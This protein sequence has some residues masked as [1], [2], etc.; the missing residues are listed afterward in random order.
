MTPVQSQS[1]DLVYSG[2]DVVARSKTGTG[3]TFAFGLPLIEK[4]VAN[5]ENEIRGGRELPLVLILEPTR[6]LALQVAQELGSV[7]GIH[8]MRVQ[9]MYGGSSFV[10]Q[11]RALRDG[12]HILVATPGRVLDHISRGTVDLSNVKHVV[13]DEGDT[14]LEMGFQKA[15]ES[16]IANVKEPGEKSRQAAAQSLQDDYD[17]FDDE[18]DTYDDDDEEEDEE[19]FPDVELGV[20]LPNGKR[21]VQM[22]L[23]SATMPGW[24]CGITDKHMKN[25]VFVDA[26]K[27]GENRLASTIKHLAMRM[28]SL[29]EPPRYG[30]RGGR[31]NSRMGSAKME[32]MKSY[33][34]DLILTKGK[35]GQTIV[36]TNTKDEADELFA[37]DCFGQLRA[38]VIHGD[39]S[40]NARQ[41][42]IK[43]FKNRKLDV[44]VATDVAARGLDIAGVDLVI[45]TSISNDHDTYVHRS[46]RTGRAG[47][48][49]TSILLYDKSNEHRMRQFENVLK[50][51][52]ENCGPP[53]ADEI[54]EASA[55]FAAS[56]IEK[57]KPTAEGFFLPHARELMIK[58]M[59][60]V[61][62][63]AELAENDEHMLDDEDDFEED[64]ADDE[65]GADL[66]EELS[67]MDDM[68]IIPEDYA[69]LDSENPALQKLLARC[70]AAL[71]NKN[72][73]SARSVLTGKPNMMTLQFDAKLSDGSSPNSVKDWQKLV[74]GVLKRSFKIDDAEIH[75]IS[76]AKNLDRDLCAMVDFD[77][78]VGKQI[79][80]EIGSVT[81][82]AGVNIHRCEIIPQI[83][84]GDTFYNRGGGDRYSSRG[85]YNGDRGSYGGGGGGGGGRG[86]S[87]DRDRGGGSYGRRDSGSGRSWDG[88]RREYGGGGRDYGRDGGRDSGRDRDGGSGRG[89]VPRSERGGGR[90]RNG[91]PSY[92]G[93]SSGRGSQRHDDWGSM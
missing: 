22:L 49:G 45:H 7:C 90:D 92:S 65:A 20:T 6:E 62:R 11:E 79:L 55:Q 35:G 29:D 67:L 76:M 57:V 63:E 54:S 48:N 88:P 17:D 61:E 9:A 27:D 72:S 3:K 46:G 24:I 5:G 73:L 28:P 71:C 32:S 43:H 1:Y 51:K 44:L 84:S 47:R 16:I 10:A 52:F 69:M 40:Q 4:L 59:K 33:M 34:E 93:A 80:S 13:L 58:Y 56:K 41:M 37:S 18:D 82:P 42:T 66:L 53:S 15:V 26:V 86:R 81:M 36:F 12:V 50:F 75:E 91:G 77:F 74:F 21:S 64:D 85:G 38:Q 30:G 8:R 83:I 87:W 31:G 89:W 25:P 60:K 78:E 68:D 70:L 2:G 19:E 14:M 39:I 23:F